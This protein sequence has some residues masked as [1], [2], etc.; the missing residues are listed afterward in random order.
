MKTVW[1]FPVGLE[2]SMV[3]LGHRVV[4][5]A[6]QGADLCVWAEVEDD[7]QRPMVAVQ[8]R[9]IGTGHPVPA[10]GEH[11]GS[12]LDGAFVWHVYEVRP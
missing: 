6:M 3:P 8:W 7:P 9:V 2:P 11:V 10:V 12:C 4:H 5:V 1:K